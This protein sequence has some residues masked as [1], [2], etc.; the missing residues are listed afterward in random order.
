MTGRAAAIQGGLA[1]LGL[2]LA[3]FTWQRE[4][5]HAPGSVTVIDATK[6]D[7]ARVHYADDKNTVDFGPNFDDHLTEPAVLPAGIPNLAS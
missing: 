6:N 1:A 5:E 2:L 4:P 3:H 7:V